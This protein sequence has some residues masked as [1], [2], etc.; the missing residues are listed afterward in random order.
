MSDR[1]G[2]G[3][4]LGTFAGVFTPSILTI[5]GIILFLRLGYVVGNAG[6]GG[7]LLIIFIATAVSVLTSMSLAAIATNI[8]VKAGGDYYL[9]SRTLGVEF[10]GAIGVVLFLAQSVSIAFYA[11]GFAEATSAVFGW[12]GQGV[13]QIIALVAVAVIFFFAWAG[14]DVA[15]RFQFVIMGA[16]VLALASFYLG[17]I[18]GYDPELARSGML[19]PG[20]AVGFWVVF[21]I[22]FPAVTGFTQGVSMSGDLRDPARSLPRGT[23]LAVA[24]STIVYVSVAVLLSGNADQS[25][26]TSDTGQAMEMAAIFGPLIILGVVAAT[27]SSAMASFLGAPRILQSLASDRIFPLL[28]PLAKGHGPTSNPRRAVLV[29]AVIAVMTIGLGNLNAVAPVVSMFFLISYGLLNYATF[30]ESR[31]KSPSFRP[32][33]RFFNQWASLAGALA[34]L[35]AMLAINAIAAAAAVAVLFGIFRYLAARRVPD[36]WADSSQ[37]HY[38]QRAKESI[39]ALTAEIDHPR[40]WR[41]QVITF[42]AN[43]ERRARLL[44][45]GKWLE[46]DSGV[47]ATFR[48]V[49]GEGVQA[50][51]ELA[52]EDEELHRQISELGV[53]VYGRA[54][55]AADALESVPVIVQSFGLGR[56]RANTVVFGWPETTDPDRYHAYVES[57]RDLARLGTNV[58]SLVGDSER[59]EALEQIPAKKRRIDVYWTDDDTG[60]LALLTAYLC[61]RTDFWQKASI[62]LLAGCESDG[63]RGTTEEDLS[64]ILA[65]A[66]ITAEIEV[67][68]DPDHEDLIALSEDAAMVMLG[69]RIRAGEMLDNAGRP[70]SGLVP[71]L[72]VTAALMAGTPVHLITQPDTG[73]GAALAEAEEAAEDARRRL[74]ILEK[75]VVDVERIVAD[76]ESIPGFSPDRRAQLAAAEE[77]LD[78]LMRR[79]LSARAR[80]EAAEKTVQEMIDSQS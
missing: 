63:D 18:P 58:V 43:P 77:R 68:V 6:L 28:T 53:E 23:F 41:P 31:A 19:P 64:Q 1:N 32:R 67:V 78:E 15:T 70:L 8:E 51:R 33:F 12:Q 26:L 42:S 65:E 3:A 25:D 11:I 22:F 2:S 37:A 74:S 66:R 44:R 71:R 38:F 57:L 80:V 69:M 46:G 61:T 60:R 54:V 16:L 62:R 13:V 20:D 27:L 79:T 36:R 49:Q 14:A 73:V 17:A 48:I 39:A 29:S 21:G 76:L 55:L 9:I 72:P 4:G 7:T 75:H 47:T 30:Y 50:R 5:L 24:V 35:G 45:F 10:G 56:L 52:A 40:N 34:C 59:W